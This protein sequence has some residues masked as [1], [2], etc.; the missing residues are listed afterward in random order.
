MKILITGGSGF[1]GSHLSHMHIAKG[2][3]V[4]VI[5]NL[6]T[7]QKENLQDLTAKPHFHFI[8]EDIT[9]VNL[10]HLPAFD[11]VYHLA[12]PASPIQYK[13]YPVVTMLTNSIGTQRLL[14]FMQKN[15]SKRFVMA[16]TSEIYGD[17]LVH[18]QDES[19][20]GNVNTLGPR[21]CYDEGKRFAEAMTMTYFRTY[22]VNVRIARIFNTYGPNMEK[23]DGRVVS[24]FIMQAITNTP[25]TI[26]GDG[27]QTRSFCYVSDLVRGLY[28]LGSTDDIDGEVI[29][30]G[31]PDERSMYDLACIIKELTQSDSEIVYKPIDADDPKKRKPDISKAK[32]I[33]GWK[34]EISLDL[35]LDQTIAYFK[36]RF[37]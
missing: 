25:I 34:P 16:S 18:P 35:G 15:E 9:T 22:G 31:N 7:G 20:F 3:E 17:P 14:E 4:Y 30:L 8:E 21:S 1:I 23:N 2:H 32:K 13:K 27:K 26:Y 19:Y 37:L 10:S 33:L 6:I 11:V 29:N 28:L 12:S 36:K 5:D 24:N